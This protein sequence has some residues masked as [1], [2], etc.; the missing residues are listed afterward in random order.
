MRDSS[1]FTDSTNTRPATHAAAATAFRPL[2]RFCEPTEAGRVL[3]SLFLLALC[4]G[5][6]TPLS[7]CVL[8]EPECR[9]SDTF[10]FY[11]RSFKVVLGGEKYYQSILLSTS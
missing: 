8:C 11:G 1:H 3:C 9:S 2:V 7:L 10:S 6:L 5:K 4:C